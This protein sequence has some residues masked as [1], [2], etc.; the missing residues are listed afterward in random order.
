M[1]QIKYYPD[2]FRY[3][4]LKPS[5]LKIF[6]EDFEDERTLKER[7]DLSL[8]ILFAEENYDTYFMPSSKDLVREALI[9]EI[10]TTGIA[11]IVN[12]KGNA[13][14]IV[15]GKLQSFKKDLKVDYYPM[16]AETFNP[17]YAYNCDIYV[18]YT[19]T[20]IN[21]QNNQKL[22]EKNF[23]GYYKRRNKAMYLFH[24]PVVLARGCQEALSQAVSINVTELTYVLES[25][26]NRR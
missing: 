22:W 21:A 8:R 19:T 25:L 6:V 2:V 7:K 24:W 20:L 15:S 10:N 17:G 5:T 3:V 11:K 16:W 12:I 14:Y 26:E 18:D 1:Y 4:K 13:D 9:E 23:T